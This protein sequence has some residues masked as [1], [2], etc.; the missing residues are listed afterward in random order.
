MSETENLDEELYPDEYSGIDELNEET[1]AEELP[2]EDKKKAINLQDLVYVKKY[3]DDYYYNK[4]ETEAL[5]DE[6][7]AD[8]VQTA[9]EDTCYT[10][11]ETYNKTVA[12]VTFYKKTDTVDKATNAVQANSASQAE[13]ASKV[14]GLEITQDT[15]GVLK[16]GDVIIPQKKVLWSKPSGMSSITDTP[17]TV[18]LSEE[19]AV[20]DVLEI[21]WESSAQPQGGRTYTKF[22]VT[23]IGDSIT[24]FNISFWSTDVLYLGSV[25]LN[26][27][28]SNQITFGIRTCAA[29]K[30]LSAADSTVKAIIDSYDD[31]T[32]D[33]HSI[34]KIIE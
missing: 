26:T 20:G 34:S 15:N 4:E 28:A 30:G 8:K 17:V 1:E 18:T 22:R 29:I 19:Y 3:I 23:S 13:N 14:N 32:Y 31:G 2:I 12:D 10:K 7:V 16:I 5:L 11:E 25:R 21:E 27:S 24:L 9:V 6:T 33:V